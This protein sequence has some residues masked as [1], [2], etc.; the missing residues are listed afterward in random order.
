M[1][2]PRKGVLSVTKAF[3]MRALQFPL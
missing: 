3:P 2:D 1:D